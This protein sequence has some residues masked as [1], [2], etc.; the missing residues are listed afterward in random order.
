MLERSSKTGE[1][2]T[3]V[4]VSRKGCHSVMPKLMCIEEDTLVLAGTVAVAADRNRTSMYARF[5]RP[6]LKRPHQQLLSPP[7]QTLWY[8]ILNLEKV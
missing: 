5:R 6:C 2:S 8:Q 4:P 7:Y 3:R 1:H